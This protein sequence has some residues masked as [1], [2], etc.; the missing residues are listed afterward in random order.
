M[1]WLYWI[2]VAFDALAVWWMLF[3]T[4]TTDSR[5]QGENRQSLFYCAACIALVRAAI[6]G[7]GY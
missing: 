7:W 6:F 4:F 2:R 3:A 1:S 5:M